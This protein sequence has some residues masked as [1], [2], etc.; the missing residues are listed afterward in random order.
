MDQNN[1]RMQTAWLVCSILFA[2]TAIRGQVS[3]GSIAGRVTDPAQAVM[4]AAAVTLTNQETGAK[5]AV[6][7]GAN[8]DYMFPIVEPGLYRLR[9]EA[10][11]FKAYE[12]SGL[13]VQ[14]AQPVTQNV[15]MAVGDTSSR[16]EVVASAPV[17]DQRSAEVG[18]VIEHREVVDLPLN[19]R[20][21]LDL[22]K[23]VPGVAELD[24]STGS[25][26]NGL[27]INGM[28]ANQIGF[29]IDGADVRTETSGKP[30]FTPSIE[31]IQEFKIQ[32][33]D[34]SADSGRN[35]VAINLTLRPGTNQFHGSGFEFLRNNDLDARSFFSPA[36]SALRRNQF[37]GVVSGPIIRNK[38]FFMVNYE[39]L[40]TSQGITRYLSVPSLNQRAGNFA[41]GNQIFD[42]TTFDSTTNTRQ[43]FPGNT[44]PASRFGLIGA[45][46][47]KYYPSPN[48]SSGGFNY[49][50]DTANVNNANQLHTRFDHQFSEKDLLFGRYSYG[51]GNNLSPGGL[52][53]T[54][55]IE[56]ILSNNITIQESHTFSPAMINQARLAWTYYKDYSGFPL[57][58]A[59]LTPDFGLIN[60]NPQSNAAG[61][62]QLVVPGLSTIGANA[63]QPTG[64]RE[65][66]FNFADDFTWIHGRHTWKLGFD[67][68]L[69]RPAALVQ[70]TPNGIITFAN[71]FSNQPNVPGTGS[72]V[73]DL[74]LGDPNSVRAT[75]FGET[76]GWVSLKY[77]YYAGYA[78]DEIRLT[79]TFVMTLGV[80]YEYQTPYNDI[81]GNL[82]DFNPVTGK[83]LKLGEQIKNLNNPD[84]NNFAPRVGLAYSLS[85]KT[86]LR[87]GFGVFYGEPRG[88][89]FS[90][91]PLSP[92]FVIDQTVVSNPLVP[93][94]IGNL[95]PIPVVRDPVTHQ[96]LE[97]PN[98]NV[99][100]LDPNFR[101][102]YTYNWNFT[103]Q[104]EIAHNILLEVG[105]VGNSAHKLTGRSLVNQAVLDVDPTHPTPVI[106]RRP[107]P[108]IGDVS[109]IEALDNSNYHS[110]AAKLNKRFSNGLSLLGAYTYSKAMG[111][112]G[113]L[114]GDQSRQQSGYDRAAEYA[115]LEFNQTQRLTVSWIYELPFGKGKPFGSNLTG[116]GGAVAG[117]W[118]FQG[119]YTAHSG[120]PLTPSSGVSSNV[121]RQD[122]NR[123]NRICNGNL[124]GG[125]RTLNRW[126]NTSCF[127]DHLFGVFGNSGNDIIGGPGVN[128]FDLAF[129]KNTRVPIG[130]RES[131][132]LQFRAELFNALNHASFGD[133]N[134]TT[135]TAQFGVIRSTSIPGRQIQLGAK[136]LF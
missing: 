47:L 48:A 135:S 108:N 131:A 58:S 77:Y 68:R 14:V 124:S 125:A 123:A 25:Q 81:Y 93:N 35:P 2:G 78:Q 87:A 80:R 117:G 41:G 71:Q 51:K 49:I 5:K 56:N 110:L 89:E 26:S 1:L 104:R 69:Y 60:L 126:F 23:L 16:V 15:Q 82:A 13:V 101:T 36:V 121:G 46:S 73:A 75:Q 43:P 122:L 66:I 134:L 37:G 67:G 102:N 32:E 42:P 106:N 97:S 53:L 98:V 12:V 50:T 113:A 90:S 40:R 44:I 24:P 76:N 4:P 9:V 65:N 52:P 21:F 28:R 112:G 29:Y 86:V 133:P 30:A 6:K 107:N 116:I 61:L 99:F 27:A 74:L 54:G 63:F 111:I 119:A 92:P 128:N 19:G 136:L 105:Y 39:G 31:A 18:Q 114:Y 118:S 59:N 10:A 96:I 83:F 109:M 33:N 70:Q 20:Q 84:G 79:P 120:F 38:T 132:T 72:A 103:I 8:G 57:A 45:S 91:F 85:P 100:S 129:M 3:T 115:P 130:R 62:P 11:G 88:S 95:F 55:T 17:L 94:L 64:P 34:F 7:T 127:P 22:A